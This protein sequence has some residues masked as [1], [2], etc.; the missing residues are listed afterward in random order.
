MTDLARQPRAKHSRKTIK[1]KAL[2]IGSIAGIEIGIHYTWLFIFVLITW[3]L[4]EGFFPNQY[5]EWNTATCWITGVIASLLLFL[6]ILLHELAH[7]LVAKARKLPIHSITLFLFGGVSGLEKEP[8]TPQDELLMT[9]AGPITSVLL[10]IVFFGISFFTHGLSEPVSAILNYLALINFILAFF[11]LLPGFPLDGGRVLRSIIWAAT[12]DYKK[13]TNIASV[14]GQAVAWMF[15]V[16]G[17]IQL[18]A[19]N[20]IGGVWIALI[21]L[22]LN[23][24]ASASRN[25]LSLNEYLSNA[26]VKDIMDPDLVTIYA[27]QSVKEAVDNIFFHHHKRAA[28]VISGDN[29]VGIITLSDVK[30]IPQDKWESTPVKDIMTTQP[31]HSV[32]IDETLNSVMELLAKYDINQVIVMANGKLKGMVTRADI[33]N[34]LQLSRELEIKPQKI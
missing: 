17:G 1:R 8:E 14:A 12:D 31:I 19:G 34:Y 28:P 24:A 13:A 2:T 11:N 25:Q 29:V 30:K 5:P 7:S 4:A 22:F 6:S 3:S 33:I 9:L 15:I 21:G 16:F 26:T 23:S 27:E 10:G 20:W 32:R 18:I